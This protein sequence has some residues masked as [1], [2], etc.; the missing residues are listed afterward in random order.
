MYFSFGVFR[1]NI[2]MPIELNNIMSYN[3]EGEVNIKWIVYLLYL[4]ETRFKHWNKF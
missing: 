4:K 1:C 3:V 2:Y